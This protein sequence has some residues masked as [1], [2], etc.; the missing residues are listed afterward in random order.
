MIYDLTKE[1]LKELEDKL[2]DAVD[3]LRANSDL[4]AAQYSTPVLGIIF[5]KFADSKYKRYE[6]EIKSIYEKLKG[7]RT[8]KPISEIAIEKCGFYLPEHARYNFLLNK[9]DKEDFP[10]LIKKAMQ[11]IEEFKLELKG[12][13]PKDEYFPLV[14]T[15]PNLIKQLLI[16]FSNI[17]DDIEGDLFGQIFGTK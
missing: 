1:Q 13:L 15:D 7:K 2:W 3:N 4:T 10:K 5:L 11:S 6:A 14:R 8:E 12:V 16:T 17:P 9:P